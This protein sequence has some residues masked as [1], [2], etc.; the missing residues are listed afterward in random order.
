MRNLGI[1]IVLSV[2]ALA[3][4]PTTGQNSAQPASVSVKPPTTQTAQGGK[5]SPSGAKVSAASVAATKAKAVSVRPAASAG[6]TGSTSQ[7]KAVSVQSASAGKAAPSTSQTKA[8]SVQATAA[9]GKPTSSSPKTTPAAKTAA[10]PSGSAKP[11]VVAIPKAASQPTAVSVK[12][13]NANAK[14]GVKGVQV[15]PV[16]VKAVTVKPV[17]GKVARPNAKVARTKPIA[18]GSGP[19]PS[20]Q[21]SNPATE[22]KQAS[23]EIHTAGR[24]D[25]FVSPVVAMG[26]GGSGCSAGKRCLTIDQIALKGVVKSEAGM[27]AVVVN[28]VD[29]AY[30][31]REND[32]VFNG[33]VVKI[34]GDS[35]IFKETFHDR[36]GKTLT[37]DVTKTITRPVA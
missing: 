29:K 19:A 30:F 33:Y 36:L 22:S 32:P 26:V 3:Q 31:L 27:I 12:S 24:R 20:V 13:G 7:T 16:T 28:A 17:I 21:E 18:A 5:P 2:A 23:Q 35:I 1:L 6:K 11:T 25:P 37:R 10:A 9:A 15:K 14:S 4:T 34:T 8:V